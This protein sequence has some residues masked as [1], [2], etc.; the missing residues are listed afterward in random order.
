[1]QQAGAKIA[2][3]G[4]L[5]GPCW[6]IRTFSHGCHSRAAVAGPYPGTGLWWLR[7]VYSKAKRSQLA[8]ADASLSDEQLQCTGMWK[9]SDMCN[10]SHFRLIPVAA[11]PVGWRPDAPPSMATALG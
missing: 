10:G 1:M 2:A 11:T 5:V 9:V 8:Q 6:P 4:G 3:R 7:P